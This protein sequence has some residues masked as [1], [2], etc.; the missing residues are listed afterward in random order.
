MPVC[1]I[2]LPLSGLE[3]VMRFKPVCYSLLFSVLTLLSACSPRYAPHLASHRDQ[4]YIIAKTYTA[5]SSVNALIAP[6]KLGVDTQMKVLVG[7]T[8][9]PLSKAQPESTLGNFVADA[10]LSAAQQIDPKVVA[11]VGNYGGIRIPYIAPGIITRGKMYELMPFDNMLTIAEIPG[12]V[13]RQFCNTM[14]ERKGWPVS[15]I[16]FTIKDKQAI[17]ILVNGALLNDNLVY[18]VAINDY[19]A[20]GGDNCDF[21]QPL[22]KRY[23]TIFLRDALMD[24]VA[25]LE[26]EG[27]PLHPVLDKRI[28]YAE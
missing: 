17:D 9:I 15:G 21:L 25:A 2:P 18:K 26:R 28:R 8:D 19:I 12:R 4:Q 23:T 1:C 10:T 7:H 3:L 27:K 6:Y 5:D 16:S 24:Y 20:R 14:A 13:L 22:Q 11:A